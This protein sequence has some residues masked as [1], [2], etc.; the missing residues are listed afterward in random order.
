MSAIAGGCLTYYA[1]VLAPWNPRFLGAKHVSV[2][3][4]V[5]FHVLK[6]AV[7]VRKLIRWLMVLLIIYVYL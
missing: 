7:K 6:H 5:Y 1:T 4:S 2:L 3:E